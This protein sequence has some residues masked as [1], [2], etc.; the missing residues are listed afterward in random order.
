MARPLS[1]SLLPA[2]SGR[3]QPSQAAPKTIEISKFQLRAGGF[4][5]SCRHH[6]LLGHRRR[7]AAHRP[8]RATP[9]SSRTHSIPG[10]SSRSLSRRR[11]SFSTSAPY[12]PHGRHDRC[13]GRPTISVSQ[14]HARRAVWGWRL[15][16]LAPVQGV[17]SCVTNRPITPLNRGRP[18]PPGSYTRLSW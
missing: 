8:S 3:Q 7:R 10:T 6:P 14:L 18:R 2:S 4:D 15:P 12:T 16:H 17:R 9:C 11:A 1:P 13:R 5:R